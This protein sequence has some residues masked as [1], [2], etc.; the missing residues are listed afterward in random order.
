MKEPQKSVGIVGLGLIGGSIGLDLQANGWL[1]KGL[2]HRASTAEKAKSRKLATVI[3]T[4]PKVLS[5]CSLV[6]LAQPLATLLKPEDALIQAL[7][8]E[9]VITDVGSVKVPVL[10]VWRDLHPNFVAS[11]PM[12]GTNNAGVEAGQKGLFKG[13]PWVTTPEKST[14]QESLE[15][16][17]QLANSLGSEWIITKAEKHDQAAAL[18]SHLPVLVS[19]ALLRTLE[20]VADAE[21]RELAERLASSGFADTT[22]VGGGNPVLGTSMAMNNT[23][24][25]L[26]Y[27]NEYKFNLRAIEE[28]ISK[29]QWGVLENELKQTQRSRKSFLKRQ[30]NDFQGKDN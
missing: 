7:P 1:V 19:A 25:I 6:I 5:D 30:K 18:I 22:R 16:V 20:E 29:E 3:S 13:R 9:G 21:V 2:T 27:L 15:V 10:K 17:C 8:P 28:E 11:H 12:A 23:K 14:N 26:E 4:D 24:A